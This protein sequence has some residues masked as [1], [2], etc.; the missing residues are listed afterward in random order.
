M[1][2]QK[3]TIILRLKSLLMVCLIAAIS[4]PLP[5]LAYLLELHNSEIM[6]MEAQAWDAIAGSNTWA[7]KQSTANYYNAILD[8]LYGACQ[9]EVGA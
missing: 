1:N 7:E 3:T 8:G 9:A 2:A 5:A 4:T 6:D